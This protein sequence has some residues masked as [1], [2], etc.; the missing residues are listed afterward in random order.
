M[1][2]TSPLQPKSPNEEQEEKTGCS[3]AGLVTFLLGLVSGTFSALLCK[4]AYDTQSAGLDGQMKPFAK[5]IM[6]LTLMFLA[7]TPAIGFWLVQQAL[8]EPSKRQ[9]V[10]MQ[11][12]AV[13][14][15]PS[16]CDLLCTLLLLV[17]QLY[18]TASLW[19]VDPL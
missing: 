4:M 5:P 16:I 2:E 19:Q 3:T 9:T 17:A 18:I 10:S 1:S 7:M 15:V 14:A 6:M 11:T 8:T 12:I 13:L